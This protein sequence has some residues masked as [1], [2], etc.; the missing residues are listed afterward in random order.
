MVPTPPP[1]D[2]RFDYEKTIEVFKLLAD[3]RFKLLA[4]VPTIVGAAIALIGDNK[5]PG[6]MIGVGVLGLCGTIGILLYELRNSEL[7]NQSIHRAKYLERL[8]NFPVSAA[9]I[10]DEKGHWPE[11]GGIFSERRR[12]GYPFLGGIAVQHDIGLGFVYSAAVGGWVY[13]IARGM[14][15]AI[16]V[17]AQSRLWVALGFAIAAGL[18]TWT[19]VLLHDH[20][21]FLPVPPHRS[22]GPK[23]KI[24]W[25]RARSLATAALLIATFIA[26]GV[27]APA[28]GPPSTS[29]SND[30]ISPE[31]VQPTAGPGA[32]GEAEQPSELAQASWL[33]WSAMGVTVLITLA[34][35]AMMFSKGRRVAGVAVTVAGAA[36]SSLLGGV[37]VKLAPNFKMENKAEINPYVQAAI[38]RA[39]AR[40]PV[41]ISDI[42][43]FASGHA[44]I[45]GSMS[46]DFDRVC[47]AWEEHS[48]HGGLLML[49]GSTDRTPLM[50]QARQR[51][52]SNA[53][54]AR[55]RAETVK[56]EIRRRCGVPLQEVLT[57]ITGPSY[58]PEHGK[59]DP[60]LKGAPDDRHVEVWAFWNATSN[61]LEFKVGGKGDKKE[62]K[63]EGKKP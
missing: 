15:T 12:G 21:Q 59:G 30:G 62:G 19:E 29:N 60:P 32:S 18:I 33:L 40:A 3:I 48:K 31:T 13:L 45:T 43:E 1:P 14:V 46:G 42:R 37:R 35:I 47:E 44:E 8:Q 56:I 38:N 20:Y 10:D 36:A 41:K 27:L 61:S 5:P 57:S 24:K 22:Y 17:S 2:L 23:E 51:Y 28:P 34:G 52:E 25:T 63:K 6:V 58:T 16:L 26:L 11:N 53:G 50:D 39:G 7:Y 55:S 9:G 54:L 4:F 49:V